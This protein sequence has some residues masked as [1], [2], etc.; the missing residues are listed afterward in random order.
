MQRVFVVYHKPFTLPD[1][2][3][4][5]GR[6]QDISLLSSSVLYCLVSHCRDVCGMVL[7]LVHTA[8]M[9][10]TRLSCLVRVYCVNWIG[11]KSRHFSVVLNIHSVPEKQPLCFLVI[12]LANEH[13][14]SQ[15]F[16]WEIPRKIFYRSII[17]TSISPWLCCYTTLR[18]LKSQHIC[19]SKTIP[20][21]SHNFFS[22]R[23]LAAKQSGSEPRRLRDVG[24]PARGCVQASQDH[25][26]GR[27]APA[28][29]GGMGPSGPGSD[30]QR[31][32]WMAQATDSLR[33]SRQ[34]TF[35]AFTLNIMASVYTMINML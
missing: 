21:S 11:D 15:F 1:T 19:V 27:A 34:R 2:M 24:D 6:R 13:R 9:D 33:C 29:R 5:Q 16:H 28:C 23:P 7:H 4:R 8:D 35:W 14:F 17:E 20:S 32:Q 3:G 22:F 18:N 12:A 30:W 10:K 31:D 26:H 25:G